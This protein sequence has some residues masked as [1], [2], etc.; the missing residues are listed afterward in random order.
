[1]RI[2]IL[3][4]PL[5]V[6]ATAGCS[7]GEAPAPAPGDTEAVPAPAGPEAVPIV[8]PPPSGSYGGTLP[9]PTDKDPQTLLTYWQGAV[10]AGDPAAADK[11]WRSGTTP[12]RP[13]TGNG[14]AVVAFG[15]GQT[16]GA[17]G[18]LYF[19][20]PVTVTVEGPDGE[21]IPATG[22]LTARRVNDVDGA[23]AEQL[24]WRIVSIDWR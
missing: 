9:G 12:V 16:E 1:M 4:V 6:M 18:S 5:F 20:A 14:P 11:A 17:A 19:T 3:A 10:E 23:T 21:P 22:T 2:A 13:P 7:G 24:S 15:P 8:T